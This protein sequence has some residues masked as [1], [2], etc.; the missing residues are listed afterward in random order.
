MK[1]LMSFAKSLPSLIL[2][3][4]EGDLTELGRKQKLSQG[5]DFGTVAWIYTVYF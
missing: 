1:S 4:L 5:L 3:N 2:L